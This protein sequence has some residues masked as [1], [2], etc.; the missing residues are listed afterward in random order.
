MNLCL[1]LMLYVEKQTNLILRS[2]KHYDS[3]HEYCD[4]VVISY[5]CD[6]KDVWM[7]R[8]YSY[9]PNLPALQD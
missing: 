8:A 6:M 9:N 3:C 7:A 4:L 2:E 1:C 5:L